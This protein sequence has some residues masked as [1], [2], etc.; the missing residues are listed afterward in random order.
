MEMDKKNASAPPLSSTS[1]K[2]FRPMG[3]AELLVRTQIMC[4]VDRNA[5]RDPTDLAFENAAPDAQAAWRR[6]NAQLVVAELDRLA[7]ER[8]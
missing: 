5:R 7:A 2:I 8:T 4:A 3:D 1:G 6:R